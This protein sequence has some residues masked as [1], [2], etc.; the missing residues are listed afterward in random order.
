MNHKILLFDI[1]TCPN[2]VSTF[3]LYPKRIPYQGILQESYVICMAA[4]WLG[5]K[6]VH[7]A[8]VKPGSNP[9]DLS[10]I[11]RLSELLYEAD[12]VVGH[13]SDN[14]DIPW[15]NSRLLK[16]GLDPLPPIKQIDTYKIAKSRFR[17][18]SYRL[19]YIGQ[20][21]EVGKKVSTPGGLW[22]RCL[23]GEKKAIEIMQAYNVGDVELLEKV[24]IKLAPFTNMRIN[25]NLVDGSRCC[26]TCGSGKLQKRGYSYTKVSK[27]ERLQ[28][29]S[30]GS[31]ST[32]KTVLT[33]EIS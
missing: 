4:K 13:Y 19:D 9:S 5:E 23:K 2:I 7:T 32:G 22:E 3:S 30:C 21:L 20:Y 25:N 18:N 28:C 11:K 15:V 26:P 33:T 17:L 1:E 14:F 27:K 29:I 16:Y 10:V 31:W 12:A 6:K 24:Y 8:S